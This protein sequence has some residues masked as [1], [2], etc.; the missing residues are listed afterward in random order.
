MR[1]LRETKLWV[2][3]N[4][5][6]LETMKDEKGNVQ[7]FETEMD[8]DLEAAGRLEIWV[9]VRVHFNHRFIQHKL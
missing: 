8:A 7:K 5:E 2:I 9:P 3:L 6:T 4:E 1:D